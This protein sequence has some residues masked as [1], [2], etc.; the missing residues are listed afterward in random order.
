MFIPSLLPSVYSLLVAVSRCWGSY[1][2]SRMEDFA[3]RPEEMI[4]HPKTHYISFSNTTRCVGPGIFHSQLLIEIEKSGYRT[5]A[6]CGELVAA[7]AF[8]ARESEMAALI[9]RM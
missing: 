3:H 4:A 6:S 5:S 2:S 1:L 7:T 9:K 8:C